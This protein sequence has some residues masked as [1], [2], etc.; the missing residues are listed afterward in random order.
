M[1]SGCDRRVAGLNG[2]IGGDRSDLPRKPRPTDTHG[3]NGPMCV[4]VDQG[5]SSARR[6]LAGAGL[7]SL[8]PVWIRTSIDA[9]LMFTDGV[10]D[11]NG[12]KLQ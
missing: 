9:I 4:H 12:R 3:G 5:G 1:F 8:V 7:V 2:V 6:G 10:K 11:S